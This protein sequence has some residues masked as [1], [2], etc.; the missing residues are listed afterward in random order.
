MGK[1]EIKQNLISLLEQNRELLNNKVDNYKE[2]LNIELKEIDDL[3]LALY[4]DEAV[5]RYLE[6]L[7]LACEDAYL[8]GESA[9]ASYMSKAGAG[10]EVLATSYKKA[11][12]L[13][14]PN[15]KRHAYAILGQYQN[16]KYSKARAIEELNKNLEIEQ[17]A[18]HHK[19]VSN[20]QGRYARVPSGTE[21]CGFCFMLCSRGFVYKDKDFSVHVNCDCMTV[22]Y[23]EGVSYGDYDPEEM[24]KRWQEC[25]NS[26]NE[27]LTQENYNK[28]LQ[29]KIDKLGDDFSYKRDYFNNSEWK[30]NQIIKEIERRDRDWV[31]TG[32]V[33]SVE[34]GSEELKNEIL[35]KRPHENRTAQRLSRNGINC[36]FQ[37]DYEYYKDNGILKKRGLPDCKR[38]IELKTLKEASAINTID[39]YIRRASKKKGIKELYFDNSNN[40]ALTDETLIEFINDARNVEYTIYILDKSGKI[41]KI[42]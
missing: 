1:Q 19:G 3:P 36:I 7:E 33:P 6:V 35:T 15:A 40:K 8:L 31:W 27:V 26:L 2:L 20:K 28:A 12:T 16:G 18:S 24:Q 22:P 30:R 42:K 11:D 25:E 37:Q 4:K 38:G 14:V 23:I 21:T 34:F 13:D 29:D 32:K 17:L 9:Y 41:K 5:K 10:A 39:G